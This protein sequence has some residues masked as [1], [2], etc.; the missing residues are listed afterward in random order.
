MHFH[1]PEQ[2]VGLTLKNKHN[3]RLTTISKFE[4][5]DNGVVLFTCEDGRYLTINDLKNHW[6][7]ITEEE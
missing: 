4:V 2:A 1:G 3:G 7:S 5:T 6:T